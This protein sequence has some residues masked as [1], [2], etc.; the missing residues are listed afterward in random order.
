[1]FCTRVALHIIIV[2]FLVLASQ[3]S[4]LKE[5]HEAA[6][7]DQNTKLKDTEEKLQS[8]NKC[9]NNHVLLESFFIIIYCNYN[10]F[11]YWHYKSLS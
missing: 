2:I 11:Q 7:A 10:Y 5:I 4:E 1:M 8:A 3:E 9:E 6:M